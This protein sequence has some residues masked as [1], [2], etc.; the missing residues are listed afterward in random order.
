[1]RIRSAGLVVLLATLSLPNLAS[2]QQPGEWLVAPYIWASDVNWDLAARGDGTVEFSDIVVHMHGVRRNFE[3]LHGDTTGSRITG[4]SSP[5]MIV[6]PRDGTGMS[7][8]AYSRQLHHQMQKHLD[9]IGKAMGTEPLNAELSAAELHRLEEQVQ[10]F[11]A[12]VDDL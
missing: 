2:A 1:M 6:R 12:K 8:E 3:E 9:Y 4:S 10:A 5:V 11:A 7:A